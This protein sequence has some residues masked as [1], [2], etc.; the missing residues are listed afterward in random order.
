MPTPPC[1]LGGSRQTPSDDFVLY[2]T[3]LP[4]YREYC[5]RELLRISGGNLRLFAGDSQLDRSVR[6]GVDQ[7]LYERLVTIRLGGRILVHLGGWRAAIA[8]SST[9]VD[10]NPR[11]TTAWALLAI[12]RLL[13]RRTLVWGHLH[14]RT[15]AASRTAGLR[16]TMRRLAS[17]TV[18]YGF[19][20]VQ[21]ALREVA[22]QPVW[23]A[24]NALY[25]AAS[26][27]AASERARIHVLYV[28]RLE[29]AKKVDLLI[30]AWAQAP[31]AAAGGRLRIVGD[32]A[33]RSRLG[34]LCEQLGVAGTVDFFGWVHDLEVLAELY[35][36][37]FCATSPGYAGLS[38]TQ[39]LGF[40]VPMV[41][42]DTEP[43]APEIELAAVPSAVE[44]FASD[45]SASMA[46]AIN[47]LSVSAPSL[48][49]DALC[50]AVR[51][52]YSAESMAGG[53]W[54]A[55]R[56]VNGEIGGGIL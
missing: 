6:T 23:V 8:A 3:V 15:G 2:L 38:L 28:G 56:G 9:V 5:L 19:A 22:G 4:I 53:L 31:I 41:V 17:G 32:G 13:G 44:F 51:L 54:D 52:H 55:V 36:S 46:A 20:S 50:A 10:L 12:R 24:A 16:R 35:S 47:R 34:E 42:A 26:L 27:T 33:E 14:P 48:N 30:R 49:R 45:N 18:L 43:H 40:G 11:C 1:R 7:A 37:A 21:P 29:P 25:Y 39:S